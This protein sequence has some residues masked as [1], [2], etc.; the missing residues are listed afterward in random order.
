M[1]G[2]DTAYLGGGNYIAYGDADD[3]DV[4]GGAG[5][6]W[7][8]GGTGQDGVIGDDGRLLTSRN[9]APPFGEPLYGVAALSHR[10]RHEI[11]QRQRAE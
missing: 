1:T 2:D 4:I 9:N 8:S 10:S 3:D 6:D 11:Q 7:V 5:H